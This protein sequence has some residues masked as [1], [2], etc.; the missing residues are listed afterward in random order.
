MVDLRFRFYAE[1]NDFLPTR[2]RGREFGVRCAPTAT[3][4][5][6]IEALGVPHTEVEVILVDGAAVDFSCRVREGARIS[7]YPCF[8]TLEIP[9][10]MRAGQTAAPAARRAHFV[11]D[12]HLGGLARLLRMA[13]F[14][15][16]YRN[17]YIDREIVAIA[18]A[19]GRIVL[20]RDRDLLKQR[21]VVRGGFVRATDPHLQFAEVVCRFALEAQA[22]P[23][24]RC[25]RCNAALHPVDIGAVS[26]RLPPSVRLRRPP[27][28]MCP[29]CR[30]VYWRGTHWQRMRQVLD[31]AFGERLTRHVAQ[32]R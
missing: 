26:E 16:L 7:V 27:L 9:D 14:D 29:E 31:A 10:T 17:D 11:A 6:L 2:R 15:T 5:H 1:L 32:A 21:G 20:T 3:V 23:F 24:T 30:R 4:K 22:Q 8:G 13:G 28:S 19:Q 25:L 18:S 12:A